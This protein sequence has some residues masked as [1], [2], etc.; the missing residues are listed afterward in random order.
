MKPKSRPGWRYEVIDLFGGR[1]RI[2]HT[3]GASVDDFW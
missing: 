2:L 1:C 3:D